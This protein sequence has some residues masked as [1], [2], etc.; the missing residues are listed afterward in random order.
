M[1][2]KRGKS[3]FD[4]QL[5][6]K[7]VQSQFDLQLQRAKRDPFVSLPFSLSLSLSLSLSFLADQ[8]R[9]TFYKQESSKVKPSRRR[10]HDHLAPFLA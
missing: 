10:R 5:Q 8:Q 2:E 4:L 1:A 3:Q 9:S 7:A 6:G